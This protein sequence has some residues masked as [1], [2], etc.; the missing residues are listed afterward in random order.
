MYYRLNNLEEVVTYLRSFVTDFHDERAKLEKQQGPREM[1]NHLRWNGASFMLLS[2][3]AAKAE[4]YLDWISKLQTEP[5]ERQATAIQKSGSVE[6][7]VFRAMKA[8]CETKV[9]HN[10]R[11]IV[12]RSTSVAANFMEDANFEFHRKLLELLTPR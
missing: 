4:D 1:A 10:S 6:A 5:S 7:F 9:L 12:S 11:D 2:A 8:E 3:Q